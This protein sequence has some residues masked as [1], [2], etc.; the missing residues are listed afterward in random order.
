MKLLQRFVMLCIAL[1]ITSCASM[2]P[3]LIEVQIPPE[4]ISQ[5]GYSLVPLNEK[6]WLIARKN[7][8]QLTIGKRGGN[9]DETFIIQA[10]SFKLPEFKTSEE[11]VRF[12]KEGQLNDTN[13]KRFTIVK[14]EVTSDPTK[15]AEC[16]KSHMVTV[17]RA[18]VKRSGMSGDM[19]L[20]ALT[21]ICAHPKDKSVGIM[22]GYSQRYYSGQRDATFDE[23]VTSILNSIEFADL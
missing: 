22:I 14:H 16:A 9:P 13:S 10:I 18:A 23:K 5:K 21:L 19:V 20:E 15:G 17:D 2:Q 8:Y 11:F 1:L 4:R 12:I 3:R 7:A 6:G